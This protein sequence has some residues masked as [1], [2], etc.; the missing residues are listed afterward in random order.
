MF[1]RNVSINMKPNSVTEFSKLFDAEA[2]PM[3][4]KQPGFRDA[5]AFANDNGTHVN[6]ISL[7][8]S[9][10]Q[11]DAYHSTGYAEIMKSLAAVVDGTPKVRTSSVINSTLATPA[12]AVTV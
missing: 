5:F 4:R 3:L 6:A 7:W 11:A 8:D 10:E 12:A 1:V 9:K 2:I